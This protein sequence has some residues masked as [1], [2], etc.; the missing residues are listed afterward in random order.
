M[1]YEVEVYRDPEAKTLVDRKVIPSVEAYFRLPLGTYHYRVRGIHR[2]GIP[3]PWG[4]LGSFT[5]TVDTPL[6]LP[7]P[8]PAAEPRAGESAKASR[9]LSA[10][11]GAAVTRIS[12]SDSH[13]GAYR[14]F[15]LTGKAGVTYARS[16]WDLQLNGFATLGSLGGRDGIA[17]RFAGVNLRAGAPVPLFRASGSWSLRLYVGYYYA[18]MFGTEDRFGFRNMHG[19]QLFPAVSKAFGGGQEAGFYLKFS[20]VSPVFGRLSLSSRELAGGASW[21]RGAAALTLDLSDIR[22]RVQGI[23]IRN[24]TVSCGVAWSL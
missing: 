13:Y 11:V 10:A 6:A 7:E 14:A 4:P 16:P 17:A 3:G 8:P 24:S 9:P 18:T 12:Y 21:S 1:E 2:L 23:A 5:L 19:P 22:L 15:A 20:P